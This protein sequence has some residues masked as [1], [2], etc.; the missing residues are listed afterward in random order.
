MQREEKRR[1]K[2]K[3]MQDEERLPR[4]NTRNA[5]VAEM[6]FMSSV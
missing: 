1:I 4:H 3:G 2:Q 5:V 6:Y